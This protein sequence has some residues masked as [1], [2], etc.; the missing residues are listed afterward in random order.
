[1]QP[2]NSKYDSIILITVTLLLVVGTVMVYS[3]SSFKAL[4]SHEDSHYYFKN[5]LMKLLIG[6]VVLLVAANVPYRFWL[7]ISPILLFLSFCALIYLLYA[8]GVKIIRNSKRWLNLGL[9]QFQ[10]SDFARLSL[11]LF[12]S[13]TLGKHSFQREITLKS[14]L[15]YLAFIA[16]LALPILKQPDL[17]SALLTAF[18]G[19]C[20]IFLAGA[21]LRHLAALAV[22]AV[23][24]LGLYIFFKGGYH[25]ERIKNFLGTWKGETSVYQTNQ[26][27]IALGNGGFFGLG[28]GDSRQK[29]DFLP[30]P[31]TD[32]IYAIIGEEL[33]IIG[34]VAI[35]ILFLILMWRAYKITMAAPDLPT[36]LLGFGIILNIGIYAFI[37][38]GVVVNL[39][40]NKGI[41][42]PFLSYGGSSMMVNLF[43]IGI[44]LNMAAQNWQSRRLHPANNYLNL[45]PYP[46]RRFRR[47]VGRRAY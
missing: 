44:L 43:F 36:K 22:T 3:A 7:R 1:M 26:S 45:R 42:M 2:L 6:V 9:M 10:P 18:I 32:F 24:T 46:T 34:T 12:L 35:L 13:F 38:A 29:Y 39:L 11:I 40:P 4:Q 15:I 5:H 25:W 20:L 27:L 19:V 14:F 41:P 21:K 8:P 23:P 30:D 28:L 47:H 37:N 31:F 16:L 33:G 17:G